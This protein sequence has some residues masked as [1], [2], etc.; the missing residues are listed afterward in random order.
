MHFTEFLLLE[1]QL[2]GHFVGFYLKKEYNN[3]MLSQGFFFFFILRA[4]WL[5]ENISPNQILRFSH[6]REK[7]ILFVHTGHFTTFK[8]VLQRTIHHVFYAVRQLV[9]TTGRAT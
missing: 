4:G 9:H 7:F 2:S 5:L 8:G 3:E 6:L 1:G